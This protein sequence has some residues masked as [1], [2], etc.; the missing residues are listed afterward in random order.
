MHENNYL[1]HLDISGMNLGDGLADLIET[2]QNSS[3]LDVVHLSDNCI[4]ESVKQLMFN[5]LNIKPEQAREMPPCSSGF[6]RLQKECSAQVK[7][8]NH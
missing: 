7:L 6:D 3:V 1:T 8:I 2:F 5:S 4:S